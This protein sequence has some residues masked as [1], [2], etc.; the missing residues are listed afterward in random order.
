MLIGPVTYIAGQA[1]FG[2]LVVSLRSAMTK[3]V[4]GRPGAAILG[5]YEGRRRTLG[6]A[7]LE[8]VVK[9]RSILGMVL[10]AALLSSAPVSV[11]WSFAGGGPLSLTVGTAS[12]AELAVPARRGVYHSRYYQS[13]LYVPYCD[14]PYVGSGWNGGT[15]WGG[16]WMD[17]SCY[18]RPVAGPVLQVRG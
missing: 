6:F 7:F 12:A 17:L 14:G 8:A 16:P 13:R 10:A 11:D 1:E 9:R 2:R 3:C 15:Y 4:R 5:N 18:E